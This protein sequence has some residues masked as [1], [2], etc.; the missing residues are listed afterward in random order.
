MDEKTLLSIIKKVKAL[1]EKSKADF[2]R[3]LS[4]SFKKIQTDERLQSFP[5]K[6]KHSQDKTVIDKANKSKKKVKAK[7]TESE[8]EA[9]YDSS[10]F[11]TK[12]NLNTKNFRSKSNASEEAN[13]KSVEEE[14]PDL[15]SSDSCSLIDTTSDKEDRS[16]QEFQD[17]DLSQLI[18]ELKANKSDK[19]KTIIC[20]IEKIVNGFSKLDKAEQQ[21]CAMVLNSMDN[22]NLITDDN[23]IKAR[24][25]E[26]RSLTKKVCIR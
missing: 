9:E 2:A 20:Q 25:N 11:Q 22:I 5:T 6:R 24:F 15:Y 1:G 23:Q 4:I 19:K 3:A 21:K 12:I 26:L 16:D 18:T 17:M 7:S 13:F 8:S 10:M 14:I